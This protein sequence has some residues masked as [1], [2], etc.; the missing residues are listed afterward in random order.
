M[1]NLILL[2][3]QILKQKLQVPTYIVGNAVTVN[4]KCK[5]DES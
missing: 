3:V 2:Y 4:Y 1:R 5:F